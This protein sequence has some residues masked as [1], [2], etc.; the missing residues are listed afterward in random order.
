[1]ETDAKNL[2]SVN[3]DTPA[4]PAKRRGSQRGREGF[5]RPARRSQ[6]SLFSALYSYSLYAFRLRQSPANSG[7]ATASKC[8]VTRRLTANRYYSSVTT[9]PSH[10]GSKGMLYCLQAAM[11][12][13]RS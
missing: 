12:V 2:E 7:F 9:C 5:G 6:S 13:S 10:R 3:Q 8:A 1:M 11:K 4:C